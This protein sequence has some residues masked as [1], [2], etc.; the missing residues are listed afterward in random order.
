MRFEIERTIDAEPGLVFDRASS[1]ADTPRF[2]S[3]ITACE[4]LTEGPVGVGTRF[5]ETRRMFGREA[6]E[7]M[8]V[9]RFERPAGYTLECTNHGCHY[10]SDLD[11]AA[12][13]DGGTR[14]SMSFDARPLNLFARIMA[15]LTSPLTRRIA[16]ECGK[17]IDD[18]KRSVEID[19]AF[20]GE[21]EKNLTKNEGK[22]VG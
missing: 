10:K 12:T 22:V 17:D 19:G 15:F 4:V 21:T 14:V 18:L 3:G 6:T 16:T 9:T 5:R 7:E 13:A 2:I 1:F 11:F 8:E 20:I